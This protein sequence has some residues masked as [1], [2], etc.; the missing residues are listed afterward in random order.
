MACSWFCFWPPQSL[1]EEQ[2][3]SEL[4]PDTHMSRSGFNRWRVSW[5]A[6]GP[7][8]PFWHGLDWG[9][10]GKYTLNLR[11]LKFLN[12]KIGSLK[13][14]LSWMGQCGLMSLQCIWSLHEK[15]SRQW[16]AQKQGPVNTRRGRAG[17]R[18]IQG[19]SPAEGMAQSALWHWVLTSGKHSS[20]VLSSA[21]I[22]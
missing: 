12:L 20:L 6:F 22:T 2:L 3:D 18:T 17:G 14:S 15:K 10:S 1:W 4:Q 9:V 8:L 11:T 5:R 13:R 21:Y 19:K 7:Y 16:K